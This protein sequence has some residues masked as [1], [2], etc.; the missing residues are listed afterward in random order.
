M[1]VIFPTEPAKVKIHLLPKNTDAITYRVTDTLVISA[2]MS[3][4]FQHIHQT[5][6]MTDDD[7]YNQHCEYCDRNCHSFLDAYYDEENGEV[8]WDHPDLEGHCSVYD[9]GY[10]GQ[11]CPRGFEKED[12]YISFDVSNMVFEIHLTH[13]GKIPRFEYVKDS[14][15]LQGIEVE[16][17]NLLKATHIE[18]ASNVFGDSSYPEGICWGY[19]PKPKNLR[20]MV[21]N[22][23]STP[24]NNDLVSLETFEENCYEIRNSSYSECEVGDEEMYLCKSADALMVLDAE[25][26]IQAFYTML[27]AGFKP[28]PKAPHVMLIPLVDCEFERNE[29]LY[30][31]YNTIPDA[32][33][34]SW[35]ISPNGEDTGL[36]V[37]QL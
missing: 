22:Y 30:R 2:W 31:G 34:K 5:T 28:L 25:E 21:T 8:D 15:Y 29:K 12:N 24:F 4:G 37:G 16:D 18:M 33:D 10:H 32:V 20:E 19:N 6:K 7:F 9:D 13:L 23:F 36:L 3:D 35:F 27:M 26:N 1:S 17:G 11:Y 14:A